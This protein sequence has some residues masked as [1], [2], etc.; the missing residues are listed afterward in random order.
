MVE[1][2]ADSREGLRSLI[3]LWGHTVEVAENGAEA[4]QKAIA[5]RPDVAL[6]DL[7]LPDL[8]GFQVAEKIRQTLHR[9]AIYLVALTGYADAPTRQRALASGF[10]AHVAKPIDSSRLS[11]ML[12]ERSGAVNGTPERSPA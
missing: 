11:S 1:D 10:D 12:A 8:D 3:E 2:D 4:V 6:I 7:G 9:D 5:G